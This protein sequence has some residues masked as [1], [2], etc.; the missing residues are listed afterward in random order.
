[1]I[2][3][4]W[5]AE[6]DGL[7]G[8]AAYVADPIVPLAQTVAYVNFDIQGTNIAPSL[9]GPDAAHRCRSRWSEVAAATQL[10]RT[11]ANAN[12]N[13]TPVFDPN[14]PTATYDDA[15]SIHNLLLRAQPDFSRFSDEDRVVSDQFVA[16]L[17]AIVDAGPGAFDDAAVARLIGGSVG[18]VEQWST[19]ECDGFLD[20]SG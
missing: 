11:L 13:D 16:D 19:G 18:I 17:G 9:R 8:S 20:N 2:V 10:L 7:L 14:T 6:E 1:M 15:V 4:L 12:A 5:D 3:A